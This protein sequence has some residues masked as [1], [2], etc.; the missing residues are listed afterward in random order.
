MRILTMEE[1]YKFFEEKQLTHYSAA[2]TGRK[3]VV[4]VPGSFSAE[5][6][7]EDGKLPVILKACHTGLNRNNSY[8]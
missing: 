2:E 8:I 1:L 6:E 7:E 3:L 5:K 4:S